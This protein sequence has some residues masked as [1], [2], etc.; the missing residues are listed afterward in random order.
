MLLAICEKKL[1]ISASIANYFKPWFDV[2]AE[3]H[4]ECNIQCDLVEMGA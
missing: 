1:A 2:R 4:S 3:E